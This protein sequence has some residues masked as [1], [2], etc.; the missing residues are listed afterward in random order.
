MLQI[1]ELNETQA[2]IFSAFQNDAVEHYQVDRLDIELGSDLES[3][4]SLDLV[5]K[6][7]MIGHLERDFEVVIPD[8]QV[9][10]IKTVEDFVLSMEEALLKKPTMP[11]AEVVETPGKY[12]SL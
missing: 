2:G 8:D 5:D 4:L 12:I 9:Y 6:M 1:N 3:D 7:E 10:K 11:V